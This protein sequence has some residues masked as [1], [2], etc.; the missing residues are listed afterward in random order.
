MVFVTSCIVSCPVCEMSQAPTQVTLGLHPRSSPEY[1]DRAPI[2]FWKGAAIHH[3]D[4][5]STDSLARTRQLHWVC[6]V[7]F[8]SRIIR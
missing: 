6:S 1:V 5:F 2:W 3:M 4:L 7:L 8:N